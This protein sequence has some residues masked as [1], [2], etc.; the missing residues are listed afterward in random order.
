[1]KAEKENAEA[2][3]RIAQAQVTSLNKQIEVSK[4]QVATTQSTVATSDNSIGLA[5]LSVKQAENNLEAAKLQLSY[6]AIT[7]PATGIISKKNVQKGQV[8]AIGQPLMAVADNQRIWVVANF[9]ETQIEKMK[10]GQEVEI[11]VD[12]YSKKAFAGKVASFH[13]HQVLNFLYCLLI[14]LPEI[15]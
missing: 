14:M 9:K 15:L 7:A 8:V 11:E 13:K 3:L 5:E 2:A 4:Y 6:C 1:M 12:A 10:E